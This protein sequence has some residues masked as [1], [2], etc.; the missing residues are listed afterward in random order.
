MWQTILD[1]WVVWA[2]GLVAAAL[3][4]FV[5]RLVKL[6]NQ[7]L[8]EERRK[9]QEE[10]KKDIIDK[11]ENEIAVEVKKSGD[12]DVEIRANIEVLEN[13]IENLTRGVLAIQGKAF[14]AGCVELLK[15][16]H[17]IT[18]DEYEQCVD[19]HDAYHLL[20]GNHRGDSLFQSV[21]EKWH[22]QL[23]K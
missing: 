20:G 12:A 9:E 22:A 4:Y 18:L 15:P 10:L 19:D 6:E 13:S 7:N 1:Y 23:G 5:R 8:R 21:Q 11:L 17:I 3:G 14:R 16:N 2:C